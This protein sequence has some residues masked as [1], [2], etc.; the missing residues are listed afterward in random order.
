MEI[1]KALAE[2]VGTVPLPRHAVAV[3]SLSQAAAGVCGLPRE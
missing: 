2:A 1:S 3:G